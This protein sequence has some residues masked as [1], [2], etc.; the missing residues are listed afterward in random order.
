M[1]YDQLRKNFRIPFPKNLEAFLL[2]M[3]GDEVPTKVHNLFLY[4]TAAARLEYA[5]SWKRK[6]IP[7]KE[8]WLQKLIEFAEL[9][10]LTAKIKMGWESFGK[11]FKKYDAKITLQVGVYKQQIQQRTT[12]RKLGWSYKSICS[13]N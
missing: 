11:Y 8:Q 7:A 4:V 1:V 12:R 13:K 9:A 5:R 3:I 10:N 2:V 6:E